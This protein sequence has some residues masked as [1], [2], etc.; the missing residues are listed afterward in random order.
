MGTVWLGLTVGCAQC[1]N[2]KYDP[3][4]QKEYY[5]MFAIWDHVDEATIDAP[6]PGQQGPY[7]RALGEY[8]KKYAA[9]KE[10]YK[11]DDWQR[12]WENRLRDAIDHPGKN[13]E[14]DFSMTSMRAMFDDADRVLKTDPAKRSHRDARRLTAFFVASRGP[15][16]EHDKEK[17]AHLNAARKELDEL[18]AGLPPY[19]QAQVI[20]ASTD[21]RQTHL[22]VRGDWKTD[23][24]PVEPGTLAFLPPVK[25]PGGT[26]YRLAF[27]RWL[28][29]RQNPLTSRV[30]VNRLWQ[31]LFG[32]GIVR[33]S[34]DFGTQG[35]KPSHPE[36]LDWLASEFV[37]RG[38]ST[39]QMVRL[40]MT[41][42]TYRQSSRARPEV[43]QKDPENMLL[44]RQSR[45]RLPAELI[46]DAALAASGLLNPAIGGPSVKPPMPKGVAEL[47]YGN[48]VKWVASEGAD[49][50]RRGLYIHYQ[51]TTPYPLLVNFD[52]PDSNVTCSRRRVSNTP[53]QALNLM[54]DPLFFE[55]AQALA[56]RTLRESPPDFNDR[57]THAFELCVGRGPS[58]SEKMRIEKFYEQKPAAKLIAAVPDGIR[59]D[60]ASTWTAI[61]R[62]LLN[63][64]EF[65]TRE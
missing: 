62:V 4:S 31:E 56:V 5:Q 30:T 35:D 9:W 38:W 21:A 34:E 12:E 39:K 17:T 47:G 20:V 37:D 42:A 15:D 14:W 41:S 55:A 23:G 61:S 54:N 63:L 7:L 58:A 48:S 40:I 19:T 10:K 13:L 46:R 6:M 51:R 2:H 24:I 26:P 64:D 44:A 16:N 43:L 22:R 52:A 8:E 49:R 3:I 33:T 25:V 45:I 50:Y 59:L 11:V 28:V 60:E 53:L 29:T 57:L 36:L 27:A 1:H 18:T 32:R 65:I